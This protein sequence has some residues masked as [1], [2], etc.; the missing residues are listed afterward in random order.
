MK[1]RIFLLLKYGIKFLYFFM[2]LLTPVQNKAV[3][4]SRQSDQPSVNFRMIERELQRADPQMQCEFYCRLGLKSEM[5]LSYALLMLR[6]M[7][8]L[9]GAKVC[10]TESY[11]IPISVLKHKPHLRII[12]IW[13]SMVAIKKFGW[14][15][16]DKPEGSSSDI[17]GI[18]QMHEGYD[19]VTVGSEYMRPF[20]AEAM[21]TPLEKILPLGMPSAD[22]ILALGVQTE[23]LREQLYAAYPQTRG[24]KIVVYVPTMRRDY[25][26]D[27]ADLAEH[28]DYEHNALIIKLHPLDR[29][30]VIDNPNAIQDTVFTTEQAIAAADAVISDYSGAAAEAALLQK[31][32]YFFTPDVAEYSGACGININPLEVFPRVSFDNADELLTAIGENRASQDDIATVRELLCG[33]CDGHSAAKIAALAFA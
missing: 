4:L 11:C 29:H 31:P 14:Q 16:V 25:A 30:T 12:Q 13:H 18:M 22:S 21:R 19:A 2:K 20:F 6:Q 8:A 5:G 15:T 17:A 10:F 7:K 26:I 33:G 9:A 1:K 24:K 23:D 27:C 3:F 28:F 32:V